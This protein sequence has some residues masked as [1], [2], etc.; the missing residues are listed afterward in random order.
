MRGGEHKEWAYERMTRS[1]FWLLCQSQ[2]HIT[3]NS[4]STSRS[5]RQAPIWDPRPIFLSPWFS[6]RQ[7]PVCYFVAP[8][9]TRGLVCHLLL[10]LVLASAV[11]PG[12]ALA[13]RRSGLSFVSISLF[14]VSMYIKYLRKI[15]KLS[16]WHSSGMY[17]QCLFQSGLGCKIS[18]SFFCIPQWNAQHSTWN[19]SRPSPLPHIVIDHAQSSCHLILHA[20]C[21]WQSII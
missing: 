13:D 12:S 1:I 8:S 7:L 2:S 4:Q 15:F 21:S 18:L 16:V 19:W 17:I 3:T 5:W 11:P 10:L 6:F 9:L 20:L 14:S